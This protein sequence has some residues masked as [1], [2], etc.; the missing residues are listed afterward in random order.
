MRTLEEQARERREK[1]D[2]RHGVASNVKKIARVMW[3]S[4]F[5]GAITIIPAA[6]WYTGKADK[7]LEMAE[8]ES[9]HL[10]AEFGMTVKNIEV[11]GR[12]KTDTN[13]LLAAIGQKPGTPII[14]F[15]V[16]AARE[17]VEELSWVRSAKVERQL[18]DTLIV[19]IVERKPLALWQTEGRDHVLIDG[20]GE[21]LQNYELG[22]YLDLP[23]LVGDDAPKAA[24]E[25]LTTL[26]TIP[27]LYDQITGAQRIG[28]RRWNIQLANGM[29]IRLPEENMELAWRRLEMLDREHGILDRDVLIVDLRLP[30]RTF[31]RLTPGA[32]EQRRNPP[33]KEGAV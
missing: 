13:A 27:H 32:A 24:A 26:Q 31:V 10:S 6:L 23:V 22:D 7:W 33:K 3:W 5:I 12:E 29:F 2:K 9:V 4:G 30:D 1:L 16:E 15:D 25:M 8:Q 17:R 21:Q 28:H 20:D 14:T 11:S 18:P 19:S